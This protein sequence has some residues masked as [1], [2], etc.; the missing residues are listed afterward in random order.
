MLVFV[1]L[2]AHRGKQLFI[3]AR[4]CELHGWKDINGVSR[5]R[6]PALD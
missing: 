2:M 3:N 6:R 4:N 5:V 1:A